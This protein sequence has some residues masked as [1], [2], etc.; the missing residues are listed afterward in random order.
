MNEI[1][2]WK[3]IKGYESYYQVSD[4]GRVRSL[5][6]IV[7][8][9]TRDRYQQLKGKILKETDNG[10]GY[11]LVFLTKDGK[12]ENKYVHILVAEA[13]IPNPDNLR[14]VNHEDLNKSNNC[15]Q[16]L[17]WVSSSRKQDTLF[18]YTS[19][20]NKKEES[21]TNKIFKCIKK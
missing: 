18:K 2:I 10:K 13:F 7:K 1:E 14:E 15:V 11:K 12:R 6:R 4:R 5:D 21:W 9:R 3:D 19:R 8:D 20:R 17:T 16:N